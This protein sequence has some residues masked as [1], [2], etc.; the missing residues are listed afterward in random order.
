VLAPV[1]VQ[2]VLPPRSHPSWGHQR[3]VDIAER[4]QHLTF[5]Q[6]EVQL[7]R[8]IRQFA[9]DHPIGAHKHGVF[10]CLRP[11]P[12]TDRGPCLPP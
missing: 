7:P 8:A 5:K 12:A 4:R 9:L 2:Q 6:A 1:G 11:D 3:G 10:R